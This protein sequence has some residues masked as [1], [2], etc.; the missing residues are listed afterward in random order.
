VEWQEQTRWVKAP[1]FRAVNHKMGRSRKKL[2][3]RFC[4]FPSNFVRTPFSARIVI[5]SID[6]DLLLAILAFRLGLIDTQQLADLCAHWRPSRAMPAGDL[7]RARGTLSDQAVAEIA[8]LLR[9]KLTEPD[10]DASA[11]LWASLDEN[12]LVELLDSDLAAIKQSVSR[13]PD[14]RVGEEATLN[15][16]GYEPRADEPETIEMEIPATDSTWLGYTG[17]LELCEPLS[18]DGMSQDYLARDHELNRDVTVKVARVWEGYSAGRD[19]FLA[20][21]RLAVQLAHPRIVPVHF[22]GN[23]SGDNAPFL[24]MRLVRGNSLQE[25]IRDYHG[26]RKRHGPHTKQLRELIG[27]VVELCDVL[28]YAHS[29]GIVHRNVKP[30]NVLIGPSHESYLIDWGLAALFDQSHRPV[31]NPLDLAD[32][33][34]LNS[35]IEGSIVGTPI[36]MSPEQIRGDLSRIGPLCDVYAV[37]VMLFQIF[38][39]ESP[40]RLNRGVP[41]LFKAV[42]LGPSPRARDVDAATPPPLDAICA[43]AMAREPADRYASALLL[44][45]DLDGW[46]SGGPIAAYP[47]SPLRRAWRHAHSLEP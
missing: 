45:R 3:P 24:I 35:H 13:P 40:F 28:E 22:V 21:A 23:R 30:V 41:E 38:T 46:L 11:G 9:E 8:D 43:R 31:E 5:M 32:C 25:K 29:R 2:P 34:K 12:T 39:G 47:E 18:R 27:W 19:R 4:R 20:E 1:S 10:R 44:K 26:Q 16:D 33:M 6:S 15:Y 36:F 37:G 7:L 17:W 42:V 14:A